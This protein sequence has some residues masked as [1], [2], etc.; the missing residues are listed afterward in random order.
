LIAVG[1]V[2][3]D[4][5]LSLDVSLDLAGRDLYGYKGVLF[6]HDYLDRMTSL[7][8][9]LDEAP[10]SL[11]GSR[12]V[13]PFRFWRKSALLCCDIFQQLPLWSAQLHKSLDLMATV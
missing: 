13:L 8:P 9:V 1:K 6:L 4:N 5:K 3:V 11:P 7:P 10:D 12:F 2:S